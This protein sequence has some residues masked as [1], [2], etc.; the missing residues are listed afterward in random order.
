MASTLIMFGT[1]CVIHPAWL[2]AITKKMLWI[3]FLEDFFMF[4]WSYNQL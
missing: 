3:F 1:L 4:G 2:P